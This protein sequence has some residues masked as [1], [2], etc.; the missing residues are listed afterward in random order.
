MLAIPVQ[1]QAEI[2]YFSDFLSV[3]SGITTILPF[4]TEC[5]FALFI[6]FLC[7]EHFYSLLKKNILVYR[8][9]QYNLVGLWLF[10]LFLFYYI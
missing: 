5:N 10:H 7:S 3:F 1:Y 2:L 8:C 4:M 9:R 6:Y